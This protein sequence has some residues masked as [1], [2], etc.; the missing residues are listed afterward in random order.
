MRTTGWRYIALTGMAW[1]LSTG[2][3]Q[4]V[5]LNVF[6][7]G[8]SLTDGMQLP[9]AFRNLV[10]E[11]GH[12]FNPE[13]PDR[14][15]FAQ[16][17]AGAPLSWHWYEEGYYDVFAPKMTT[18]EW[19][20]LVLQPFQRRLF[21]WSSSNNREEGDVPMSTNFIH[22]V[23]A[24]GLSSNVQVYIYSHWPR[25]ATEPDFDFKE[26]W[27][28][29]VDF[30]EWHQDDRR[31]YFEALLDEVRDAYRFGLAQEP[32]LIPVGDVLYELNERLMATPQ[33]GPDGIVYTNVHQ[34]YGDA[35]H[36]KPGVGR[37]VMAATTLAT[38]YRQDPRGLSAGLYNEVSTYYPQYQG[39]FEELTPNMLALIQDVV[40]EVVSTHPHAGVLRDRDGDGID[41]A[42]AWTHF[43][44]AERVHPDEDPD[45]DGMTNLEEFI[46]GTNPH[47]SHSVFRGSLHSADGS[48]RFKWP[49]RS[50]RVY[51]VEWTPC[52]RTLDFET[53][54]DELPWTEAGWEIPP[55][56]RHGYYRV[57][58][59]FD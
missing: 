23:T 55:A 52:L 22:L 47:D 6:L 9:T 58:V 4:A 59:R 16:I 27:D 49:G 53:V 5:D 12:A 57:R 50:G 44:G 42:W 31:D 26:R 3:G 13:H 38:V 21:S 28:S 15:D 29:P 14:G 19:D 34:L 33:S 7:V 54:A 10:A 18:H 40:W 46:A 45:A 39:Q 24:Q 36:L 11:S 8:N 2:S 25:W 43:G 20:V 56:D 30:G 37:Y 35:T 41:D 1:A 51:T 32:M 48:F 17:A